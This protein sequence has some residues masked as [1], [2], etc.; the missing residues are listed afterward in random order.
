M[1]ETIIV[2]KQNELVCAQLM[3][4]VLVELEEIQQS[5]SALTYWLNRHGVQQ[6][7][8]IVDLQEEELYVDRHPSL[9]TWEMKAYAE[10]QL[11]RRFPSSQF[12]RSHYTHAAQLPWKAVSG[13]LS[14][15]GFNEHE[16]L[17]KLMDWLEAAQI[18]VQ[19]LHSS[20]TV[21]QTALLN[22][23]FAS[24]KR[25]ALFQ[26]QSLVFL[27]RVDEQ[28]FKQFL[29]INGQ[30]RTN[31]QIHID[32]NESSEQMK[33]LIQEVNLLEKFAKTQK[34]LEPSSSLTVFYL[35][36]D[37]ED[38]QT[39]LTAFQQSSF[40]A[41]VYE[42]QFAN[43]Q[44]LIADLNL[45][46][47]YDRLLVLTLSRSRLASDYRPKIVQ[48][49][50]AVQQARSALW[51]TWVVATLALVGY[52]LAFVT[53]QHETEQSV[54]RL[55]QVKQAQKDYIARFMSYN[56]IPFLN[57]YALNDIK[58]TIDAQDAIARMQSQQALLPLLEPL[59]QVMSQHHAI[60]LLAFSLSGTA[61][62]PAPAPKLGD[63]RSGQDGRLT[64]LQLSLSI[65]VSAQSRLAE[66]IE[67]V[68][69][70]VSALNNVDPV[71]L[72]QAKITKVP[73]TVDSNQPLKFNLQEGL[74]QD[75][76]AIPF[77]VSV[78][79]AYE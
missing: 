37:A 9:F 19:S 15:S 59:S 54:Q 27:V 44:S 7:K 53:H 63:A 17:D 33:W 75:V 34:L 26:K 23:W 6:V 21:W 46:Q 30:L 14:M 36:R 48:Q 50:Q 69:Q 57:Q 28:D 29:F 40:A 10:R 25:N 52:G 16:M 18:R 13:E 24:R 5:Q 49:V 58:L 62:T 3:Q 70:F 35:G 12:S 66:K 8:V 67:Q 39:A 11:H 61:T 79:L 60:T 71:H 78:A 2:I 45:S 20:M 42:G 72:K 1:H 73:F 74:E 41:G 22:T 68:N 64:E 4:Q 76:I 31:R 43:I 38:S 56:D 65:Q 55:N 77:E 51:V 47:L 32:A